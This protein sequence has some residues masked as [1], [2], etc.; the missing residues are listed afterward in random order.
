M[1]ADARDQSKLWLGDGSGE[2]WPPPYSRSECLSLNTVDILGQIILF[3]VLGWLAA[4]LGL[5]PPGAGS[6]LLTSYDNQE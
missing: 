1:L 2:C 6:V 4:S 3:C 5:C